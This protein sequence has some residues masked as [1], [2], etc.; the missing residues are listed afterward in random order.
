LGAF[1]FARPIEWSL[2]DRPTPDGKSTEKFVERNRD[3]VGPKA[4]VTLGWE[5]CGANP[6]EA[7]P[8]SYL[9]D[10]LSPTVG[11]D[12]QSPW[13]HLA[14]G[15]TPVSIWGLRLVAGVTLNQSQLIP[16]GVNS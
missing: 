16:A 2:G 3:V 8:S 9:C 5:W 14:I 7:S 1:D 13:K 4:F 10:L 15:V 11:F 12:I 6:S